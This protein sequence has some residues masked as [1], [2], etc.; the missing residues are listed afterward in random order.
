M[1]ITY[2]LKGTEIEIRELKSITLDLNKKHIT[3]Q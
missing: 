3:F 2:E 1:S